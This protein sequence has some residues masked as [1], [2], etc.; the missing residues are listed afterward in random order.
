MHARAGVI[1]R[2]LP[3][4]CTPSNSHALSAERLGGACP[5]SAH[6]PLSRIVRRSQDDLRALLFC[7]LP[8]SGSSA[9]GGL[10][11]WR[12]STRMGMPQKV[13]YGEGGNTHRWWVVELLPQLGRTPML[14]GHPLANRW[15]TT[16][17]TRIRDPARSFVDIA[18]P[19]PDSA[20]TT[21]F[22]QGRQI[23]R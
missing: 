4:P 21:H 2:V 1:E 5:S 16:C 8:T 10:A 17:P 19:P 7:I 3:R 15:S 14:R 11:S 6:C 13:M 9:S 22:G 23:G 18:P 20:S 12:E